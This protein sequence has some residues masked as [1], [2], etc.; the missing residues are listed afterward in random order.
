[1]IFENS[2]KQLIDNDMEFGTYVKKDYIEIGLP[3]LDDNISDF[4][5][6]KRENEN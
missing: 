4:D 3:N 1:M 6:L 5:R 2:R